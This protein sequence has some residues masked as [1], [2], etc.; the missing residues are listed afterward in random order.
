MNKYYVKWDIYR[1]MVMAISPITACSKVFRYRFDET[2]KQEC[3]TIRFDNIMWVSEKGFD[4]HGD[5]ILVD[6]QWVIEQIQIE[7]ERLTHEN[8]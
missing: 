4:K 2:I 7:N 6:V 3:G 5:D 1:R 8:S